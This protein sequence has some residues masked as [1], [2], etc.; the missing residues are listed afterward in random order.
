MNDLAM[1]LVNPNC[2]IA[3]ARRLGKQENAKQ[4]DDGEGG[5]VLAR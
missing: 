5:K 1:I 3:K 2:D 4:L